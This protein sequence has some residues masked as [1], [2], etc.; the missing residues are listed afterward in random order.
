MEDVPAAAAAISGGWFPV[1]MDI[2]VRC[3]GNQGGSGRH[4]HLSDAD[5]RSGNDPI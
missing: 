4:A 1:H 2:A 5:G 3:Y